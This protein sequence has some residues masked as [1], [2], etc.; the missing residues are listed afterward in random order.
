MIHLC[1]GKRAD[2]KSWSRFS[3]GVNQHYSIEVKQAK[4]IYTSS[5][6]GTAGGELE[7]DLN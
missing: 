6:A 2:Y 7:K 4:Q 5:G 3:A 1:Q